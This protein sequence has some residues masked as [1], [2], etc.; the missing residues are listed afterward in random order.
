MLRLAMDKSLRTVDEFGRMRVEMSNISK[1]TVNPY[2]GAEI[3]KYESLGL[4]PD[5]VYYLLRDPVE[6]AKAAPTFNG[7]PIL[8][9]HV[10]V[11]ADAPSQEYTV[12]STGTD[13][14]FDEP[15]LR[16]SLILWTAGAI[17][18]VKS[19]QQTELSSAYSYDADMTPGTF[20]G[21][22]Y[23]G[24]MRNIKGNH[25]ALV[26]VGR[27]G[28]DVV[29]GDSKLLEKPNMK[30]SA[31]A[32]TVRAALMGFLLPRLAQDAQIGDLSAI[33]GSVKALVGAKEKKAIVAAV[34]SAYTPKLAQDADLE[35]LVQLLDVLGE[36]DT[37]DV[38]PAALDDGDMRSKLA[39]AGVPEDKIGACLA[40]IAGTA[41]D[42][43]PE[44]DKGDKVDKPA[45]DAAIN[46]A[47]AKTRADTIA[48]MQAIATAEKEVAPYIGKLAVA[49][50]S[51]E[52]IYKLALDHA[53]VDLTNVP[54]AA[55]RAMVGMLAKQAAASVPRIAQDAAGVK[56]FAEMFPGAGKMK[57][58]V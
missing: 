48:H 58:G 45:M 47:V 54:P 32:K 12:G 51:A 27:A 1:A 28:P 26:E 52:A 4:D 53:K 57:G 39:A 20:G 5:K 10:P 9:R 44:I 36:D 40:A 3:P 41:G 56:S 13:A 30:L 18:G 37:D 38:P 16:N 19:K 2:R 14:V 29:V 17:A 42:A 11:S 43:D 22:R 21:M 8:D 35:G 31:K 25:V 34:T 49:Q 33:T 46:A 55:Y 23:D 15:Y 7:L 6:L 50:D 24:V